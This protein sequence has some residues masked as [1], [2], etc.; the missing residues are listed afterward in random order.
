MRQTILDTSPAQALYSARYIDQRTFTVW[1]S[2]PQ[3]PMRE[4]EVRV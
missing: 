2:S 1:T 3:L 4:V